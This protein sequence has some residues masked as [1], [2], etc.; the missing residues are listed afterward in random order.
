M[1]CNKVNLCGIRNSKV[2][3][4]QKQTKMNLNKFQIKL[5]KKLKF[6]KI[7]CQPNFYQILTTEILNLNW[8]FKHHLLCIK[9][10]CLISYK[11]TKTLWNLNKFSFSNPEA[12]LNRIL[13]HLK[14]LFSNNLFFFKMKY[15]SDFYGM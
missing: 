5:R 1:T 15:E 2:F 3:C 4:K 13:K 7:L 9:T 10:I 14:I 11:H 12:K 6:S 8:P